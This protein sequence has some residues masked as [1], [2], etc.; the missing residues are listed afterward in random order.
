[1]L[2]YALAA[3]V[4]ATVAQEFARGIR[5][6]RAL[7]GETPMTAFASLIRRS[8]RRYGGY[9]V[10]LGI[11]VIAVAVAT[12]QAGTIEVERTL[13]QGEVMRVGDYDIHFT[14]VRSVSE[15]QRDKVVA[16]LAA[17][18]PGAITDL[19]TVTASLVYYPNSTQAIGSPG[20]APGPR[21]D[22]Y[23]ILVAYDTQ[24][25]TWA[26]IRVLV[27]PLVSWIWLGGAI[28]GLGAVIAALPPPR[29]G[30]LRVRIMRELPATDAQ[31]V[32]SAPRREV[33]P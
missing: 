30:S 32:R 28:V 21:D 25:F 18:A 9:V 27:I 26:T 16:I 17:S 7:H 3:F 10:H 14:G 12:S 20:V 29:A 2:T 11:V 8:G 22:I 5:A 13:M 33:E 23:T 6:R 4:A 24:S 31:F 1:V 15:P 19:R